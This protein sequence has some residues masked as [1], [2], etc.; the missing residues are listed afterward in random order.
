LF[1]VLGS[2]ADLVEA[3]AFEAAVAKYPGSLLNPQG[4]RESAPMTRVKHRQLGIA[5]VGAAEPPTERAVDI[6]Q[7]HHIRVDVGLVI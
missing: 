2:V 7:H 3:H 4:A 1:E 5:I 6:L